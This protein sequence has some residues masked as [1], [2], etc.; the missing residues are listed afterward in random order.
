MQRILWNYLAAALF[1]GV[2]AIAIAEMVARLVLPPPQ[3]VTVQPALD[4][5]DRRENEKWQHLVL[6]IPS[7]PEQAKQH[8]Y[9]MTLA[10]RRMRANTTAVV[11]NHSMSGRHIEIHTNSI[12]YRNRE[13]GP[14][15]GTRLLFLGDSIT[16]GAYLPEEETFVRQVEQRAQAQGRGWE[17]INSGISGISLKTELAILHE[18][19]LALEPDIVVLGFYLNDFQESPGVF[20]QQ[21]P[22]VVQRSFLFHYLL[23]SFY[24]EVPDYSPST[25]VTDSNNPRV[26]MPRDMW[27]MHELA[28]ERTASWRAEFDKTKEGLSGEEGS[29]YARVST[30]FD[31]WGGVWSPHTWEVLEPLFGELKRLGHERG[32]RVVVLCFPVLDQVVAERVYDEPQRYLAKLARDMGMEYLDLLP[33]LREQ[34]DPRGLFYDHCHHTS[35]GNT[36][37]A[38]AVYSFLKAN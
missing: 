30:S 20:V 8:F 28:A 6:E 11:E 23:K 4:L 34:D 37:I 3:I 22:W 36:V 19:G 17:T 13:I 5:T 15:Q 1:S 9:R 7:S 27:R 25:F 38:E 14:K 16:L 21:M 26:S 35:R 29:F 31:D 18:T 2:I 33:V 32:F 10:G 24:I 12:G